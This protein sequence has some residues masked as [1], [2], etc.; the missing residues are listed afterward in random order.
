MFAA[1]QRV[2]LLGDAEAPARARRA[3]ERLLT[4]ARV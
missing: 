3:F 2:H 4:D 1:H